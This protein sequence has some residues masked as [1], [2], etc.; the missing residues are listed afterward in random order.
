[1]R[2]TDQVVV[3]GRRKDRRHE[4]H[5]MLQACG[6]FIPKPCKRGGSGRVAPALRQRLGI[7]FFTDQPVRHFGD[8]QY[9]VCGGIVL[10]EMDEVFQH[11]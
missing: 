11:R 5:T 2:R 6:K 8:C 9:E 3:F 4:Q 1:M 10:V 7:D